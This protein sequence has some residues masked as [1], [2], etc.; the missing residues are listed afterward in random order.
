V[1]DSRHFLRSAALGVR[2]G[3]SRDGALRAVTIANAKML[4][5]DHRVGSLEQGKDADF[6]I[7]SGDPLS[8]YTRVEQT[9]VE[10]RKVFDLSNPQDRLYA[11]GGDGAG[12]PSR[13]VLCCFGSAWDIIANANA[14]LFGASQ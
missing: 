11:L 8:V 14:Q 13:P 7:L 5:L 4:G 10:G 9:W 1:T 12:D 2:A 3:M 6:I